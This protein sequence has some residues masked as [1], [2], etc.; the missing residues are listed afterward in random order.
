MKCKFCNKSLKGKRSDA[1]FCSHNCQVK[2][3]HNNK[4][5]LRIEKEHKL[6]DEATQ[7]KRSGKIDE[8]IQVLETDNNTLKTKVN[9]Y[10]RF[11][12]RLLTDINSLKAEIKQFKDDIAY[13]EVEVLLDDE[14]FYKKHLKKENK[15]SRNHSSWLL[16]SLVNISTALQEAGQMEEKVFNE[17]V[18]ISIEITRLKEQI[19]ENEDLIVTHKKKLNQFAP[20]SNSYIN[21]IKQN[22]DRIKHLETLKFTPTPS[23]LP[24][25]TKTL[26]KTK[27]GDVGG[28]DLLNMKFETF[29]LEGELGR[30]LGELDRNMTSFA[31]TGDSGSGKSYFSFELAKLFIDYGFT[32]K[33]FSLEEGLGKLTQDKLLKYNIGNELILSGKA[34]LSEI[35]KD[36]KEYD[37]V[38]IDSFQKLETEASEFEHLRQSFPKTIFI[39]IFQKT[40]NGTIRGGSS[41]KF[42]SSATIDVRIEENERV[43]Y[44][45]KG[46]YGTMGWKYSVSENIILS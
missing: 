42:N 1:K 32:C 11:K 33:Y 20:I 9:Q 45:E 23:L 41:I 6:K 28:A 7:A 43:A 34:T 30:F 38:I 22:N 12:E 19:Q 29:K 13:W 18:K 24:S 46:R 25:K 37:V 39:I 40:T 44:M 3:H 2:W 16:N 5:Q 4:K 27:K 17:K 8:R 21:L 31:L 10:A 14:P 15:A 36:A 26:Q 35:R